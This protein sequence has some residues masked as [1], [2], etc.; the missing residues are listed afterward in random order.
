M[1]I[2][3]IIAYLKNNEAR[4]SRETL[5]VQLRKSGYPEEEIQSALKARDGVIAPA[6][7]SVGAP[8]W[9]KIAA[10][11]GGFLAAGV[12]F[13][14]AAIG[15]VILALASAFGGIEEIWIFMALA[16]SALLIAGAVFL[17]VKIHRRHPAFSWGILAA[18]I[19]FGF[20]MTWASIMFVG[21]PGRI[22]G[23]G[24]GDAREKSRDALR[25]AN[26]KQLQLALELYYDSEQMYPVE[27]NLLAPRYIPTLPRDPATGAYYRYEKRPDGGYYLSAALE[28]PNHH[29][30]QDDINPGNM[31]YEVSEGPVQSQ[32]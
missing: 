4:F 25:V 20:S 32:F 14:A 8:I 21:M 5:L 18:T 26:I 2:E 15:V 3:D 19:I 10:G 13:G 29:L 1:A 28:D 11:L 31:L 17:F 24:I 6:V 30:L 7:Y 12:L 27:L 23:V 22:G 16:G 9:K